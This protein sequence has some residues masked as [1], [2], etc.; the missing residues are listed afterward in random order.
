M[1]DSFSDLLSSLPLSSPFLSVQSLCSF[2]D[3][4][5]LAIITLVQEC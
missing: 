2:L 3:S 4:A 1:S 5:P